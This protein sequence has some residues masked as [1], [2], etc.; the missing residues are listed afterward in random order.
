[1]VQPDAAAEFLSDPILRNQGLLSRILAAQPDN[2]AG[3]RFY[4]DTEAAD[5]KTIQS[6][7]QHVLR[8]LQEPWPLAEGERNVLAP[9]A[10]T[11]D[12]S[13]F[14]VWKEF[15]DG[16]ERR[17]D[18]S[19]ELATIEDFAAKAAEQAA[20]IAGVL[21]VV[22][23]HRATDITAATMRDAV[24][25]ADWYVNE[26]LRLQQGGRTDPMLVRA[27]KLLDWLRTRGSEVDVRDII[28]FGPPTERSKKAAEQTLAILRS[29]GW[30]KV[31]SK[32]PY[33][34]SVVQASTQGE[35]S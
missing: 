15:Y 18:Q 17:C 26:T 20:R 6:Y 22:A 2:L 7:S 30:V 25:I 34:I 21:T 23:D 28:T 35:G 13:A 33:R 8:I 19:G 9:P 12:M 11:M 31:I 1:M 14:E 3:T 4:R 10:L 27:Q 29:H 16:V 24:K 32:R 5:L